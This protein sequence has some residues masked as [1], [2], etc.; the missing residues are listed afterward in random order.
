MGF[1]ESKLKR[2]GRH[3]EYLPHIEGSYEE[4]SNCPFDH[5]IRNR[6]REQRVFE[7]VHGEDVIGFRSAP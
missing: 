5:S 3:E 6:I 2:M 7:A 1:L 4:R